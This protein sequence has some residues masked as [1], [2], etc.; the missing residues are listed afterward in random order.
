LLAKSGDLIGGLMECD[1]CGETLDNAGPLGRV[2]CKKCGLVPM[3]ERCAKIHEGERCDEVY[4]CGATDKS[5]DQWE[6]VG[7]ISVDSGTVQI[8]DPCYD[9]NTE[10][11]RCWTLFCSQIKGAVTPL[12]HKT[13]RHGKAVVVSNFGGDG[14]Y[15]VYIKRGTENEIA[16][17]KVDF[18]GHGGEG[19]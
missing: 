8:G 13:G 9:Y 2:K 4:P 19:Q 10:D 12:V 17:M 18:T 3:C 5:L 11:K 7:H 1:T 15:P 6:F 16:Q 14:A